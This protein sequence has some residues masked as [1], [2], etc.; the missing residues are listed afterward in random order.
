MRARAQVLSGFLN[1]IFLVFVSIFVLIESAERFYEPPGAPAWRLLSPA[2]AA[3]A[4]AAAAEAYLSD[5]KPRLLVHQPY[6]AERPSP[7]ES[8]ARPNNQRARARA[9]DAPA[10][11]RT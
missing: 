3:A 2:A 9:R 7:A 10:A 6:C 11:R 1:G 5:I 4:A 8:F